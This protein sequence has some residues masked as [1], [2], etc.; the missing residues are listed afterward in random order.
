MTTPASF[1]IGPTPL[2]GVD[3]FCLQVLP[4][5][6]GRGPDEGVD[7]ISSESIKNFLRELQDGDLTKQRWF[8]LIDRR[9]TFEVRSTYE[10]WYRISD[11]LSIKKRS[12][13]ESKSVT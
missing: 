2:M 7:A 3:T 13:A 9:E 6:G 5:L 4:Y 8:T 11:K 1:K 12:N 10:E